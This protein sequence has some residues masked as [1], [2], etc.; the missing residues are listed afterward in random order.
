MFLSYLNGNESEV[1]WAIEENTV[2]N[3]SPQTPIHFFHGDADVT[4]PYQNVMTAISKF[5]SNGANNILLTT[6]PGGNHATSGA[7]ASIGAIQWF[8]NL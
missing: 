6:I 3:W 2:L 8:E 1:V 5:E 4:V 7:A